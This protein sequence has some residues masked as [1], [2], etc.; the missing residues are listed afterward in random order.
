MWLEVQES[1]ESGTSQSC[2]VLPIKMPT[3]QTGHGYACA[4]SCSQMAGQ[5]TW[6]VQCRNTNAGVQSVQQ[7]VRCHTWLLGQL[8]MTLS[9]SLN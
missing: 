2:T 3:A 1:A 5:H 4:M 8:G 7:P 9:F 6:R